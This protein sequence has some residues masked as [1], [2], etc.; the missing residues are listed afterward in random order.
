MAHTALHARILRP[1]SFTRPSLA[2]STTT[3]FRAALPLGCNHH[4]W[5][6]G[7]VTTDISTDSGAG[8]DMMPREGDDMRTCL[9][10]PGSF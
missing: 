3:T 5:R 2:F 6:P 10:A 7:M 4:A 1:A 9:L 8:H